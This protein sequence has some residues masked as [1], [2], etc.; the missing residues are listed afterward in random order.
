M[1]CGIEAQ[2]RDPVILQPEDR[3][4]Q[5]QPLVLR[6]FCLHLPDAVHPVAVR[7]LH[8]RLDA[9]RNDLGYHIVRG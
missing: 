7:L 6:K 1:L 2:Q 8:T 5:L 9:D 3:G 4:L